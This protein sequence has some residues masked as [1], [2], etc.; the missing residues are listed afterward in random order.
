ME[1]ERQWCDNIECRDFGKVTAGNIK[2][3]SYA[4]RRY[5]CTTCRRTFSA[6]RGT[7]WE[8]I[9]SPRSVVLESL[10]LLNERN[11]LRAAGR[12]KQRSPNRL[13]GWWGLAGPHSAV[14]SA[15]VIHDLHL[16]QVQVDELWTFVKK[17]RAPAT[18]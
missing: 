3:F 11:S 4:E 5:Y 9:R 18:G 14:V 13:L 2:V 10:A 7:F 17:T 1:L 15:V 12:L 8:T 6:D 16:T